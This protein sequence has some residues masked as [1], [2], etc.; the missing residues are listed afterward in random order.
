[1]DDLVVLQT[2]SSQLEASLV[3]DVLREEEIPCF[4]RTTNF[5][6]GAADGAWSAA[7]P[8][9]IVVRA[10]QAARAREVLASRRPL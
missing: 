2:V 5:A 8:R 9:E 3:C 1:V 6:A 7:G 4:A 10:D